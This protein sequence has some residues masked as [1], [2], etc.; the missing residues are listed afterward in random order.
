MASRRPCG[1]SGGEDEPGKTIPSGTVRGTRRI[2]VKP[3]CEAS[4]RA[5]PDPDLR[6]RALSCAARTARSRLDTRPSF[7]DE[8]RTAPGGTFARLERRSSAPSL[9]AAAHG[10][11]VGRTHTRV[12][13]PFPTPTYAA[14]PPLGPPAPRIDLHRDGICL[15]AKPEHTLARSRGE[16]AAGCRAE[17]RRLA[18]CP[19]FAGEG[20]L[21]ARAW[22]LVRPGRRRHDRPGRNWGEHDE[23]RL[24]HQE[25]RAMSVRHVPGLSLERVRKGQERDDRL[26]A[27]CTAARRGHRRDLLCRRRRDVEVQRSRRDEGVSMPELSC[28]GGLWSDRDVLLHPRPGSLILILVSGARRH[29]RPRPRRRD[30]VARQVAARGARRRC[31]AHRWTPWQGR[32]SVPSW[33]RFPYESGRPE[34]QPTRDHLERASGRSPLRPAV[35][36]PGG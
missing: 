4:D 15:P 11:R 36:E 24:H 6:G 33:A 13:S 16:C 29:G 20:P 22:R 3:L 9:V 2:S 17:M 5:G 32:R 8:L 21:V 27:R 31:E 19:A 26:E 12:G 35:R 18:L 28:L 25:R 1:P 7:A 34:T 23:S 30:S 14:P 10:A